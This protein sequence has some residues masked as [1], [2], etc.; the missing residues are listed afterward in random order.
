MTAYEY[1]GRIVLDDTTLDLLADRVAE[2]LENRTKASSPE[3]SEGWLTTK[4][5]ADYLAISYDRM[6]KLAAARIIP[7]AQE[8]AGG[9]RYFTRSD[10]DAYRR[11]EKS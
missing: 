3:I 9:K 8:A 1:T 2:C 11:G 6:G 5:A 10:L 7:S 4:Q